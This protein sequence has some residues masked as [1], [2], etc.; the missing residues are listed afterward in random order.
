MSNA[1]IMIGQK[2]LLS[3]SFVAG[4]WSFEAPDIAD[5]FM[6]TLNP[7]TDELIGV[8]QLANQY[9]IRKAARHS[10]IGFASWRDTS[11]DDR[12]RAL[13]RIAENIRN[14]A[15]EIAHLLT[16]E[17]GKPLSESRSEVEASANLFEYFAE[18]GKR[19]HGRVLMRPVGQ[20]SIVVRQPVGPVA[21]FTPWNFPV[22]LMAK[23]IAAALAAGCSIISKPAEETPHSTALAFRC[24]VE[25]DIPDGAAQLLFGEPSEVSSLLIAA[26][27]IRKISFTGSVPVGRK[28]MELAAAVGKPV[29]MELG[30]HSPVLVFKDCDLETALD[31]CVAQ[32]FR[33]AGQACV[34]PTRFLVEQQIYDDFVR[35][36]S[37]RMAKLRIGNGLDC[38]TQLGP[39]ANPKRKLYVQT[40]IE[41]AVQCGAGLIGGGITE[42]FGNFLK[43]ALLTDVSS[44]A[45]IS[46]EEPFGPVAIATR[47]DD[48]E[49]AINEANR[50]PFGLAAFVFTKDGSTANYAADRIEAGMVGIN[51]FAIGPS[52]AP[53]GGVKDSGFGSEGGPEGLATY[54]VTKAIHSA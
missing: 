53:F 3:G 33:N 8:V 54:L 27:E 19:N 2:Q 46:L 48:V 52:D 25:A 24:V 21:A 41:Q 30:G 31:A 23:K 34:S 38:H 12:G 36:F 18:E 22:F 51:S 15:E 42:V 13:R 17:Q 28:L 50:L 11:P 45:R 32:K 40:L 16:I 43:P 20:R 39:V 4:R 5:A 10:M 6:E 26:D 35:G 1:N 37:E 49:N 47:F 9:L 44:E 14:R 7:A 29:T